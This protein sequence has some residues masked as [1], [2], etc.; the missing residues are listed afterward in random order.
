MQ[1]LRHIDAERG[2]F[3]AR[4]CAIICGIAMALTLGMF[5]Q[6]AFADEADA[7]DNGN[8][9]EVSEGTTDGTDSQERSSAPSDESTQSEHPVVAIPSNETP[10]A[11]PLGAQT[12]YVSSLASGDVKTMTPIVPD[13]SL[14][15]LYSGLEITTSDISEISTTPIPWAPFIFSVLSLVLLASGVSVIIYSLSQPIK[16]D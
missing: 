13:A 15:Q 14:G 10:L 12:E 5:V 1:D 8:A 9:P 6:S 16:T 3:V 7:S 11:A 2:S 4:A